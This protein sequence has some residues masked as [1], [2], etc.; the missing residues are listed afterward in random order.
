MKAALF[1]QL[2]A[3]HCVEMYTNA[4]RVDLALQLSC[5]GYSLK[6]ELQ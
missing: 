1:D 3:T 5:R 6:Q 4:A 2:Q